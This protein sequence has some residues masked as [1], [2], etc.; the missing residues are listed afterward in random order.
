MKEYIIKTR[1]INVRNAMV[2]F[3]DLYAVVELSLIHI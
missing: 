2:D 3:Q 1:I